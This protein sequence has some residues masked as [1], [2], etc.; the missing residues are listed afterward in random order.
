MHNL[1]QMI[2]SRA[3]DL[4]KIQEERHIYFSFRGYEIDTDL[5]IWCRF[6][7]DSCGGHDYASVFLDIK[8][9][10]MDNDDW[11]AYY[12]ELVI[13]KENAEKAQLASV[14]KAERENK[15]R[16]FKSLK[17]ELTASGVSGKE[18]A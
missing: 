9:I 16:I 1:Q 6:E 12:L 8:Y 10:E 4:L 13:K 11:A 14:Q 5:E 17:K 7:D 15:L 2:E 18:L 3:E